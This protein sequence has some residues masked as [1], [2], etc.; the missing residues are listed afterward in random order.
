M[1]PG[2]GGSGS[3]SIPGARA[4]FCT[5]NQRET[6]W[7]A[8]QR[9]LL[10]PWIRGIGRTLRAVSSLLHVASPGCRDGWVG[11]LPRTLLPGQ[12]LGR[13]LSKNTCQWPLPSSR[14]GRGLGE[15]ASQGMGGCGG[16]EDVTSG[17]EK[18]VKDQPCVDATSRPPPC[19]VSLESLRLA[20]FPWRES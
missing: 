10:R 19:I 1:D 4:I 7:L 16:G 12:T 11:I 3:E 6:W 8:P 13:T 18:T 20:H 14:R 17:S 9:I 5:A 2:R 15:P